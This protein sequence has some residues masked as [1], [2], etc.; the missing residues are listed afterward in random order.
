MVQLL[1]QVSGI[2]SISGAM[3]L[4]LCRDKTNA[5]RYDEHLRF[6]YNIY[7]FSSTK[8]GFQETKIFFNVS[9][10]TNFYVNI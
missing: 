7:M 6:I 4:G 8:N 5:I 9:L 2:Y 1:E 10:K 3:Y